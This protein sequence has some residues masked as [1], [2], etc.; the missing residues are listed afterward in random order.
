MKKIDF[1]LISD[2]GSD[3]TLIPI[4]RWL[5][6][7]T[8]NQIP[9][10]GE[11]ADFSRINNPPKTLTDC[12]CRT[13]EFYAPDLLFVHRDAEAQDPQ[14]RFDEIDQAIIETKQKMPERSVPY[15]CI[16]PIR[17]T[18]AW[19]LF[20]ENAIRKAAG[21]PKGSVEIRLPAFNRLEDLPD[22]K[23][24]LFSILTD[25]SELSGR[26]KKR[27]NPAKRRYLI[28]D[29]ID[30]YKPLMALSAFKR[31]HEDINKFVADRNL[32]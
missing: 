15:I 8:L 4:V 25:A 1:A 12:I 14:L 3:K 5:L 11:W 26:N 22:P 24:L 7:Q 32:N 9:I 19:L 10:N 21:N 6:Q 16:V 23:R 31:L 2:G 30:D 27:F 17:M 28:A 20:D 29:Y 18:E 13:I